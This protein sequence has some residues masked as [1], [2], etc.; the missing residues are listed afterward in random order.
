MAQTTIANGATGAVARAAIN[1]NFA[2]LFPGTVSSISYN[3]D[4]TVN[5]I[6]RADGW[7]DTHAYT[8]GL[9]S[10]IVR[11]KSG[12]PTTTTTITRNI[13]GQI[14]SYTVVSA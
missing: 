10:S 6:T 4:G 14:T 8:D 11:T 13:S 5:V 3:L 2:E 1:N 12:Q 7:V 9:L